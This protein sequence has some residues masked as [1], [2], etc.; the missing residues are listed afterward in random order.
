MVVL[1]CWPSSVQCSQAKQLPD[2]MILF[3]GTHW[4]IQLDMDCLP[5]T[6]LPTHTH[7][8]RAGQLYQKLLPGLLTHIPTLGAMCA[9]INLCNCTHTHTQA[10]T[11]INKMEPK[12]RIP[13]ANTHTNIL[14]ICTHTLTCA[15]A[16]HLWTLEE[17]RDIWLQA[18][19]SAAYPS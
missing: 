17:C 14:Y 5:T 9:T 19:I 6:T 10:L 2:D 16:T 12:H 7:T 3:T 8:S 11:T 13:H 15:H 4:T 18:F 1:G